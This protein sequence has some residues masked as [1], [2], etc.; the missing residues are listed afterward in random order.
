MAGERSS[1]IDRGVESLTPR[2]RAG[3]LPIRRPPFFGGGDLAGS[4][5]SHSSNQK[6]RV[7]ETLV[8]NEMPLNVFLG[9]YSFHEKF[10]AR[11]CLNPHLRAIILPAS[12]GRL[13]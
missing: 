9:E 13:N 11:S 8:E 1:F 12:S 4:R 5:E 3:S 2:F 6:K 7:R 10:V